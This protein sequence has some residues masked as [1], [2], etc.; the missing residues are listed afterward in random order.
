VA[1]PAVSGLL[2]T[3]SSVPT[4]YEKPWSHDVVLD[5]DTGTYF[6][7]AVCG[8]S[9]IYTLRVRLTP[10]EVKKFLAD[11]TSLESLASQ[12]AYSPSAFADRTVK[13]SP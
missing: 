8:D 1:D 3:N 5:E 12:I 9:A 6:I 11:P 13:Q 7:D 2:F 10:E 4:L